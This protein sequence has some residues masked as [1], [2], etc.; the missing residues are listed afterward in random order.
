MI[1]Y[2]LKDGSGRNREVG[3]IQ[4]LQSVYNFTHVPFPSTT[5]RVLSRRLTRLFPRVHVLFRK[6][7]DLS[8]AVSSIGPVCLQRRRCDDFCYSIFRMFRGLVVLYTWI[9]K[10]GLV[11]SSY[12]CH[13]L[14]LTAN[15]PRYDSQYI[16]RPITRRLTQ[17]FDL[18]NV[19]NDGEMTD[20][21]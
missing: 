21:M 15:T 10:Q 17:R 6:W 3:R 19:H 18:Y 1:N 2:I 4:A 16:S 5:S 20:K 14:P 9:S 12:S 13:V 7:R 11:K 8:A